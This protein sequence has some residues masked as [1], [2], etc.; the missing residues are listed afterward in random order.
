MP[1]PSPKV[2]VADKTAMNLCRLGVILGLTEKNF[3][4]ER[5]FV[6]SWR[7]YGLIEPECDGVKAYREFLEQGRTE[8]P[9]IVI[10]TLDKY[11]L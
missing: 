1:T 2:F 8:L 6:L 11:D 10:R 5:V 7:D 4:E 3:S 9:V